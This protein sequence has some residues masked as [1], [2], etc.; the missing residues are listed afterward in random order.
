[1]LGSLLSDVQRFDC[2]EKND[3]GR[4]K[5]ALKLTKNQ[6]ILMYARAVWMSLSR[7]FVCNRFP[8]YLHTTTGAP[9]VRGAEALASARVRRRGRPHQVPA[10]GMCKGKEMKG[11]RGK[12][13]V[14]LVCIY[15]YTCSP[16]VLARKVKR[17]RARE[18]QGEYVG[19]K[20]E[21]QAHLE[22]YVRARV[23]CR[24]AFV[25]WCFPFPSH[26]HTMHAH[27]RAHRFYGER[28][29]ECSE[30]LRRA[31]LSPASE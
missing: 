18:V 11:R 16:R 30:I 28:M 1:M 13:T 3:I 27:V 4:V 21:M 5:S 15:Q 23:Q 8:M 2:L 31:K 26:T 25:L 7:V 12:R 6:V 9:G 24:P 29:A 14:L 22:K 19:R 10:H 17:R 20:A